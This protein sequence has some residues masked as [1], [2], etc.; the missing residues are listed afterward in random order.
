MSTEHGKLCHEVR[1]KL[2][3]LV[4]GELDDTARAAV[5]QHLSFCPGCQFEW[6]DHEVVWRCLSRCEDVD[7]PEELRDRVRRAIADHE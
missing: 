1:V 6:H 3:A 5:E 4:A 2:P 7:P